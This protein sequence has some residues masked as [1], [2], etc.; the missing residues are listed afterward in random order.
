MTCGLSKS[1]QVHNCF[2]FYHIVQCQSLKWVKICHKLSNSK[3]L[4][5][6]VFAQMQLRN[7]SGGLVSVESQLSLNH[8]SVESQS[9]LSRVSVE[10]QSIFF[11]IVVLRIKFFLKVKV[12]AQVR[13]FTS[14]WTF[15]KFLAVFAL[16]LYSNSEANVEE[17]VLI[18]NL[19]VFLCQ[20]SFQFYCTTTKLG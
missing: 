10:S 4:L 17:K 11:L 12:S 8:V 3:L 15:L 13:F 7:W 19:F 20:R 9:S 1:V 18:R 2:W 5:K 14:S 16:M 6:T